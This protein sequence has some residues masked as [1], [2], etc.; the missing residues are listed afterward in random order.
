MSSGPGRSSRARAALCSSSKLMSADWASFHGALD[1]CDPDL[2]GKNGWRVVGGF[3]SP[4]AEM[5]TA[6]TEG[7]EVKATPGLRR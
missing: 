1:V 3:G 4:D 6:G 5:H 2:P 7:N